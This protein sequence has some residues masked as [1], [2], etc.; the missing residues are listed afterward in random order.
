MKHIQLSL[1]LRRRIDSI[2]HTINHTSALLTFLET[3]EFT[4]KFTT[5]A[6]QLQASLTI[7]ITDLT[8]LLSCAA[9][10]H[11]LSFCIVT[12]EVR[13]HSNSVF[14]DDFNTNFFLLH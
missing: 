7:T 14:P 6:T 12:P 1:V 8:M 3:I 10:R 9:V 2:L 13:F 11:N 5:N 4:H